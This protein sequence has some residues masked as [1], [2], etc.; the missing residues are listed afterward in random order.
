[1]LLHQAVPGGPLGAVALV[2]DNDAIWRPLA[3]GPCHARWAPDRM[4][5][6]GLKP[7]AA[8][9]SLRRQPADV[10]PLLRPS[11]GVGVRVRLAASGRRSRP[12]RALKG[13][14]RT[15]RV[16]ARTVEI[17]AQQSFALV[18]PTPFMVI[19]NAGALRSQ[20]SQQVVWE[21]SWTVRRGPPAGRRM[22]TRRRPAKLASR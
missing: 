1:M 16:A 19:A 9:Q 20:R 22:H 14:S 8:P 21:P 3:C 11:T 7:C 2:V 17:R 4:S 18:R 6:H 12:R 13:R 10:R 15:A 5:P